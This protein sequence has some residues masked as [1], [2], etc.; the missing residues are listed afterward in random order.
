[1]QAL[2]MIIRGDIVLTMNARAEIFRPGWIH[3][4]DGAIRAV[5]PEPIRVR[6]DEAEAAED[7]GHVPHQ[8]ISPAHGCHDGTDQDRGEQDLDRD[9]EHV[10][11]S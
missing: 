11:I 6:E 9:L 2:G 4:V 10:H 5:S 7:E 8:R 3:I 1:M